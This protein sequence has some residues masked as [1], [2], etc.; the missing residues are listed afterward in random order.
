MSIDVDDFRPKMSHTP[1]SQLQKVLRGHSIPIRRKQESNR[2]AFR[3]DCSVQIGPSTSHA[4]IGFI[5]TPRPV[6]VA[7]MAPYALVQ[8]RRIVQDSTSNGGVIHAESPFGNQFF[9]LAVTERVPQIPTNTQQDHLL[10]K[11]SS[12]KSCRPAFAHSVH[13]ISPTSAI[14]DTACARGA[15]TILNGPTPLY[16]AYDAGHCRRVPARKPR[17]ISTAFPSLSYSGYKAE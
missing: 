4:H 1:Q 9:Q 14:G 6:W 3:I 12:L 11:M 8:K 5:H 13:L 17:L 16:D 10:L 15:A 7:K 2:I